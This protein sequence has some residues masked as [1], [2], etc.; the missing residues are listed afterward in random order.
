MPA[1]NVQSLIDQLHEE[2]EMDRPNDL[3]PDVGIIMGSDS[4]LPTMAGGQGKRPGAYAALADELGFEEQ[5][6]YTDAPESRFTFETFVCSAHR[7][8]DLMYAYAETAADRG[9]DVIIA[10]AGGKSADLPNMTASIAY[11]L[12]VIGVPVQEKSVDSVIGMPQ[13]APMTAVDAGKSFNA[14]LSAAQILARQHDELRDRLVSY[15]EGLQA[16]VGEASRDLHELGTPG[17]KRE[18]WDE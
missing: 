17:F 12:P 5:T 1:D 18:Y 3:T 2:A 9:I 16:D 4:D 13:G 15:H 7:T 11:P 6:D 8:P 10:G 14:A